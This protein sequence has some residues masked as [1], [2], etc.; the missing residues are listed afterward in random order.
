MDT[1]PPGKYF[2]LCGLRVNRP[3]REQPPAGR[4]QASGDINP[5]TGQPIDPDGHDCTLPDS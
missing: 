5:L 2:G 4:T 3:V 1:A